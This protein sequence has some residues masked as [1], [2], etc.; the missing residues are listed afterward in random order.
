M[1]LAQQ[2]CTG[3][4]LS[5]CAM[6]STDLIKKY[7]IIPQYEYRVESY[8]KH[9]IPKYILEYQDE[10]TIMTQIITTRTINLH[11]EFP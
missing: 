6:L 4:M 11:W 1:L 7:T 9:Y 10:L 5:P 2:L 8:V 3:T